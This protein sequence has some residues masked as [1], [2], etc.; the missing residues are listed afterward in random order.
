MVHFLRMVFLPI[1]DG[2]AYGHEAG[3]SAFVVEDLPFCR[4]LFAQFIGDIF[5]KRRNQ[6]VFALAGGPL[7]A[8]R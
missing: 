1:T 3:I 8:G 4:A 6:L 5:G 2:S 7:A